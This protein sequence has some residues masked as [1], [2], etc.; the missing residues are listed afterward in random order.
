MF[1]A[2]LPWQWRR[3]ALTHGCQQA[4]RE[5]RQH[6]PSRVTFRSPDNSSNS[7]RWWPGL[8]EPVPIVS[9]HLPR[10][11]LFW[12]LFYRGGK[13]RLRKV[14]SADRSYTVRQ[15]QRGKTQVHIHQITKRSA[16]LFFFPEIA[17]MLTLIGS[18]YRGVTN[19]DAAKGQGG[20]KQVKGA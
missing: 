3:Q 2:V 13:L 5:V 14:G 1:L 16:I 4:P 18:G 11:T 7:S 15:W 20:D 19:S 10:V 12:P 17:K 6:L 9:S 8:A